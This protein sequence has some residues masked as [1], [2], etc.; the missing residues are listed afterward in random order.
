MLHRSLLRPTGRPRRD[1]PS[2]LAKWGASLTG[3]ML[4]KQKCSR[5]RVH[6]PADEAAPCGSGTPRTSGC[7]TPSTWWAFV[8]VRE[9][10]WAHDAYQQARARGQMHNRAL[11]GIGALWTRILW[12]CWS[13]HRTYDTALHLKN[14]HTEA[15]TA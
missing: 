8:S 9:N 7:G 3:E 5:N 13:D 6:A 4:A 1:S 15:I 14:Q 10:P 11:R 12:R 2:V